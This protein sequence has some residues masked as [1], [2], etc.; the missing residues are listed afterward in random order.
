MK[1][2]GI[3]GKIGS[4]KSA[5]GG[6]LSERGAFVLDLDREMHALYAESELLRQ[7]IADRFGAN[8]IRENAVDRIA[9]ANCVFKDVNSL[10][11]LENIVYP[12]LQERVESK[13]LAKASSPNSPKLA[14]IEG[15][16]LFKWPEF[17][18]RL[19]EIWIVEAPDSLRLERLMQ[20]GL[21]REDAE[22]RMQIQAQDPLPPNA[23]YAHIDNSS[24]L[25]SVLSQIQKLTQI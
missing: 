1:T 17:S 5:V 18:H 20:R 16:L 7:K 2:I 24:S 21:S 15:A 8:C 9:L 4:G 10:A 14:A 13:L 11:D 19:S 6:L 22:R 12:I 23:H 3:C 25:D